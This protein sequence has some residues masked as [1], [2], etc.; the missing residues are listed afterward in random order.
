[1]RAQYSPLGHPPSQ[2]WRQLAG[3]L[4]AVVVAAV[5]TFT[6]LWAYSPF[7]I[8]PCIG[9]DEDCSLESSPTP[10]PSSSG[11]ASPPFTYSSVTIQNLPYQRR[12]VYGTVMDIHGGNVWLQPDLGLY[13]MFGVSFGFCVEPQNGT[14][15]DLQGGNGG[16]DGIGTQVFAGCFNTTC[17]SHLNHNISCYTS[18]DLANW[19]PIHG[20]GP[21][22]AIIYQMTD[23][24]TPGIAF[25]AKGLWN[26]QYQYWVLWVNWDAPP[27]NNGHTSALTAPANGSV[28]TIQTLIIDTFAYTENFV[29]D[30]N[31][32]I[33][34]DG[35]GYV[36]YAGNAADDPGHDTAIEQL[37]P[38][39]LATLGEAAWSGTIVSYV[40]AAAM[41]KRNGLYWISYGVCSCYGYNDTLL[42]LASSSSALGP[43][44]LPGTPVSA[45]ITGQQ[46]TTF[47]Y[48]DGNGTLQHMLWMDQWQTAPPPGYKAYDYN[49]W[50]PLLWTV[51]GSPVALPNL[52]LIN[53]TVATGPG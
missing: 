16:V 33:D 46:S 52:P 18:P 20:P 28:W 35:T 27:D 15:G 9:H 21:T 31:F 3:V 24:P 6:L 1:M 51:D 29:D 36:I 8:I 45:S 11:L 39:F 48:Y 37:T 34:D 25:E 22:G 50:T 49:H 38:D 40:E 13:F 23:W 32:F 2:R 7:S 47:A 30:Q 26:E 17:G 44:S 10:T 5:V 14:Y 41:F 12:D 42:Y 53:L 19:T 43:Y 4:L